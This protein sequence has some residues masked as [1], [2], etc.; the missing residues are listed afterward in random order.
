MRAVLRQALAEL[1]RRRLQTMVI[2]VVALLTSGAATLAANLLLETD[3]PFQHA[4]AAA[5]GAHLTLTFDG[6]AVSAAELAAT[7]HAPGVTAASGPWEELGVVLDTPDNAGAGPAPGPLRDIPVAVR[8]R[9]RPDTAVDRLTL[10]S[11]RW[12]TGP[13]EIVLSRSASLRFGVGVGDRLVATR[14]P[15]TPQLAVV[16]VAAS[17]ISDFGAWV[18]PQDLPGLT[19]PGAPWSRPLYQVAYR[20]SP[21]ATPDDLTRAARS[22]TSGLPAGAVTDTVSYLDVQRSADLLSSVM[23]PFLIAFSVFALAATVMVVGNVIT[24]V[25]ISS[26]RDIGVMKSVGFSPGQ[27]TGVLALE[28]LL[29]AALGAAAGTGLG[30]LASV[31]FLTKTATALALPAPFTA[32]GPIAA[33]VVAGMLVLVL[34]AALVPAW[35]AGRLSAVTAITRGSSPGAIGNGRLG[36]TLGRL[37]LPSAVRIGLADVLAR[38]LRAAMTL[39]A[40]TVGVTTVVFALGLHLSLQEVAHHLI[41]DHYVQVEAQLTGDGSIDQAEALI[42]ADHDTA[43]SVAEGRT[44]LSLTGVAQPVPYYGYRG[45]ASWIGYALING[46]WFARPGEVVAPTRFL[47]QSGLHVG[48]TFTAVTRPSGGTVRLTLVGE[49]LDQQDDD[50]LLRGGWTAIAAAEPRA[51]L[52][53]FEIQLQPGAGADAYVNRLVDASGGTLQAD[54]T[55]GSDTDISFVLLQTVV[56]GLAVVLIAIAVAGVFNTVVLTTRE[57]VRDVAILK[58]VG[59][60]PGQVVTMVVASVAALGLVAGLAGVPLG[61][62]L[63]AEVL[64]LMAQTAS[65][66]GIPPGFVDVIAH[67]QLPALGLAGVAVAALGAWLPARWAALGPVAEVLQAE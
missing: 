1:R 15:G 19:Q 7:M 30:S 31:P 8:S 16:G 49:I 35:R 50:V 52:D 57:R 61:R 33:V 12:A 29:P 13:G 32:F 51:Q 26:Q 41:R 4:F 11:G 66:T 38:P 40:I 27:V 54:T 10:Q 37:P 23:V 60:G 28:V 64:G 45:D 47:R 34:L 17:V 14:V 62:L 24:G 3:A 63:H 25:V 56:G 58:A 67:W 55:H 9:D 65:G 43:R 39:G 46:R 5:N 36:A 42:A 21:A 18:R 48:D 22:I 2:A 20:V 6:T 44:E 59:M 53:S